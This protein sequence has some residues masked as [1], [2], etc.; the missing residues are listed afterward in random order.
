V[1]RPTKI[2]FG[3]MRRSSGGRGVLIYCA[4]YQCSHWI[5]LRAD[6]WPDDVRLHR[7]RL[8]VNRLDDSVGP[9]DLSG[10]RSSALFFG[11]RDSRPQP[12]PL[13]T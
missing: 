10:I 4:D 3:E 1:N 12:Q 6:Q 13:L 2:T 5:K 7:H 9:R 8:R 11:S